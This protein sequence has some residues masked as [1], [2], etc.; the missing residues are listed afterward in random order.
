MTPDPP[1]PL[2]L[3]EALLPTDEA[4]V[5]YAEGRTDEARRL[6]EAAILAGS[7]DTM[8]WAMLFQLCREQGDWPAF[9]M[10]SERCAGALGRAAPA[11]LD[12]QDLALLPEGIDPDAVSRQAPAG[13][14]HAAAAGA[15]ADQLGDSAGHPRYI[16]TTRISRIDDEGAG[17]LSGALRAHMQAGDG[18]VVA[19]AQRL[20]RLLRDTL[21]ED[22][23][24]HGCWSLLLD[25]HQLQGEQAEFERAALEYALATGGQPPAWQPL[26]APL[27]TRSAVTEKRDAPRYQS[28]PEKLLLRGALDSA[29]DE[30]LDALRAFAGDRQYVNVDLSAASRLAPAAAAALVALA[31]RQVDSG[32]V[33]RLLRPNPL[34]Q[35]LLET[36]ELDARV[37]LVPA[38]SL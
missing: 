12:A 29:A 17:V 35:A 34:V 5:L 6:L 2:I 27:T 22:A 16:D 20:E 37:Q 10:L 36:L 7:R 4:A 38:A 21:T 25:L 30:Q 24:L 13:M 31:N 1:V 19:G 23:D 26:L 3:A 9:V 33:V 28:A 18:L 8:M 15:F 11:W 14:L 32:K